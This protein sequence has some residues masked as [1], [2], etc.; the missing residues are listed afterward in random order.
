MSAQASVDHRHPVTSSPCPRWC[1]TQHG[2][3]LGEEDW[4][5]SS[6]PVPVD[7]ELVA[8]LCMSVDPN[9]GAEDGPFV[10]IGTSEYTVAEAR[11][12]GRSLMTL[13]TTGDTDGQ[14]DGGR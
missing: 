11:A 10:L 5:H 14:D 6:A 13:A 4:I 9:T 8:R 12:L 3:H 1:V 2:V 7:E